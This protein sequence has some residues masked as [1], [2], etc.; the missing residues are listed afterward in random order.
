MVGKKAPNAGGGFK[1]LPICQTLPRLMS[2]HYHT[3]FV[4]NRTMEH[5]SQKY[6]NENSDKYCKNNISFTTSSGNFVTF[7]Q[8]CQ[9]REENQIYTRIKRLVS[10]KVDPR[11]FL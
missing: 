10:V 2:K 1:N 9:G 8:T 6:T 7:L 3:F 11:F 4:Q 5:T